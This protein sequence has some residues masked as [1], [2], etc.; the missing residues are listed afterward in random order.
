MEITIKE[1]TYEFI[2]GFNF[3]QEINRRNQ[4]YLD[5][6]VTL[7]AGV[8]NTVFNLVGG[9]IET[10]I[11]ALHVA[12]A[13]EKP[14]VGINTLAEHIAENEDTDF[15]TMVFDELKK[16]AFTKKKAIE[17]EAEMQEAE[18]KAKA[19]ARKK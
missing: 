1:K 18:K 12:N 4:V 16:S 14:R 13:T 5:N 8:E 9:D 17:I 6:G 11:T 10:L 2:F 3:L 7:N 19:K 15:F